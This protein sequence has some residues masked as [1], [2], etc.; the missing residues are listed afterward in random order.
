MKIKDILLYF[1]RG[2]YSTVAK[3]YRAD[4][5]DKAKDKIIE[6]G[7]YHFVP[8][9]KVAQAIV[10]SEYLKPATGG[11]MKYINSYGTPVACMFMG[12]PDADNFTKNL[13]GTKIENNPY[14]NPCMIATA[15]KVSPTSK[16]DLKNYKLRNLSDDAILYEGYCVLP[17]E[18]ITIEKLVPDLVRDENNN[19]IKNSKGDYTVAFR[20]IKPEEMIE[21][22]DIYLAQ[23]DYLDYMKLKAKEYGYSKND[24]M[25]GKINN[26]I[27]NVVDQSRMESQKATEGIKQNLNGNLNNIFSKFKNFIKKISTPKI[28]DTVEN[29]LDNFEFGMKNPFQDKKFGTFIAKTQSEKGLEQIKLKDALVDLNSSKE[30]E[31]LKKKYEISKDIVTKSGIHGKNHTNRVLINS[32]IIAKQEGMFENDS[33]NRIKDILMMA[34]I[35]HD[36]GRIGDNGP[37]AARSA[38][39]IEKMDLKF[40]DGKEYLKDDKNLLKAIVDA[41]EGKPDKIYKTIK[42]YGV[43]DKDKELALKLSSILRDADALDRVRIDSV[44]LTTTKVN[45]NP[46]YLVNDTSKKLVVGAYELENLTKN[47]S[48]E[49][50]FEFGKEKTENE[51]DKK[52]KVDANV[53]ENKDILKEDVNK[54]NKEQ[55]FGGPEL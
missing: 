14:V 20:K 23:K 47:K 3:T 15:V 19:P 49:S 53:K 37:H 4:I 33:T 16:E 43:A 11:V 40:L 46:N 29:V 39:K 12:K 27:T 17:H 9:E 30:G 38:R 54:K 8:N 34:A 24:H 26:Y 13:T 5:D 31:Y 36:I 42:K 55:D 2:F 44:R 45:L 52:Y 18:K 25:V 35:C 7:M 22:S 32:A 28:E 41:H 50:I 21:G 6:E 48:M 51:F 10:D 1:P